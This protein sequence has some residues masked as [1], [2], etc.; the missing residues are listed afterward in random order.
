MLINNNSVWIVLSVISLVNFGDKN[1]FVVLILSCI[2]K[3]AFTECS[4]ILMISFPLFVTRLL[5]ASRCNDGRT[6]G[7]AFRTD[8][9]V[10]F[11]NA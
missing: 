4:D 9:I 10:T 7:N 11:I 8:S 1:C 3:V 2:F 5:L 6:V